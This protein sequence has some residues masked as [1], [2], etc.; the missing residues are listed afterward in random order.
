VPWAWTSPWSALR[1][2]AVVRR[3]SWSCTHRCRGWRGL[4]PYTVPPSEDPQRT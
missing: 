4:S 3:R 1:M 2:R